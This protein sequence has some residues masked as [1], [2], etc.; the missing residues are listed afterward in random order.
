MSH[1]PASPATLR[2]PFRT[3]DLFNLTVIVDARLS[4]DGRLVALV[5]QRADLDRNHTTSGLWLVSTDV[6]GSMATPRRLTNG[7]AADTA[8]RWSPDGR[9][10]AYLSDCGGTRQLYLLDF[11]ADGWGRP[12]RRL[13]DLS[14]AV[15]TRLVAGRH[16]ARLH[17]E[18]RR[19]S[20][21]RRARPARRRHPTPHPPPLPLRRHRLPR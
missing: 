13:T 3:E 5:L 7:E 21:R 11:A 15:S 18:R 16:S 19:R 9:Q 6:E 17:D 20:R 10:L 1:T 2:Q 8:P 14:R 12:A 4:P